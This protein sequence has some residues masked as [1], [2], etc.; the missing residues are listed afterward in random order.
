MTASPGREAKSLNFAVRSR[1]AEVATKEFNVFAEW[2]MGRFE[3]V[4][5]FLF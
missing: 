4:D 5:K 2:V 3:I 1:E